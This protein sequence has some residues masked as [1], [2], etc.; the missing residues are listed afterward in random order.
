[1]EV[2][3]IDVVRMTTGEAN[4]A[5]AELELRGDPAARLRRS[6]RFGIHRSS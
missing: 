4:D 3:R 1:V 2:E 6:S 5:M